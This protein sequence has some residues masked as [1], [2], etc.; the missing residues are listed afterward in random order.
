MHRHPRRTASAVA[1]ATAA[2]LLSGCSSGSSASSAVSSAAAVVNSGASALASAANGVSSAAASAQSAAASALAGVTDGV[3]A[4]A[5]VMLGA[6]TTA[7]DGRSEVP[8]TV[9]NHGSKAYR[10][11]VEV[12][13]EDSSGKALDVVVLSV[14]ETAASATAQATARSNRNLSGTVTAKV[15]AALRY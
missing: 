1:L 8:V 3:D 10:Y 6:V 14:P 5:D 4:K 12:T 2:A 15:G 13:F 11:S 7:S 9:T